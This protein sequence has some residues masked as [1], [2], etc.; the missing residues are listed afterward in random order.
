MK[1]TTCLWHFDS[2]KGK[3]VSFN[4]AKTCTYTTCLALFAFMHQWSFL[5]L[6]ICIAGIKSYI[7]DMVTN[8]FSKN[9]EKY[10]R[11][12]FKAIQAWEAFL[13]FNLKPDVCGCRDINGTAVKHFLRGRKRLLQSPLQ[14]SQMSLFTGVVW[15]CIPLRVISLREKPGSSAGRYMKAWWSILLASC[16]F[17]KTFSLCAK[18]SF[19]TANLDHVLVLQKSGFFIS[20][21]GCGW[22][23]GMLTNQRGVEAF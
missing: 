20:K 15:S 18:V 11:A 1:K 10:G 5:C 4:R 19:N 2:Q 22:L 17:F 6:R 9:R 3:I 21:T 13:T 7:H 12:I 16:S 8:H 14:A 23:S